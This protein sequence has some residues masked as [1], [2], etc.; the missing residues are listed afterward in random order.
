MNIK[1]LIKNA[2]NAL[3]LDLTKNLKYDRL[4]YKVINQVVKK[5]SIC[6]DIGCHKGEI[7]DKI[8]KNAPN[9]KHYA[10]EPIPSLYKQLKEKYKETTIVFPYALSDNEGEVR[11]NHV[12]NAPEYSGILQRT[13]FGLK[14]PDIEK[15]IVETM[16]L[17]SLVPANSKID[18]IKIDVEGGEF[19]VLRGAQ[20]VLKE[21]K[22][23]VVFECGLGGSEFYGTKPEALFDYLDKEINLKVSLLDR[24]IQN[25]PPLTKE[26]FSNTFYKGLEFYFIAYP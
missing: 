14:E 4:T 18:F 12:K 9:Q 23:V 8:L 6:I 2:L 11:F 5:D 25:E 7:L 21:S 20:R 17:D 26:E 22:P 24:W 13:Y 16:K 15:V 10:F 1:S 3:H 19:P